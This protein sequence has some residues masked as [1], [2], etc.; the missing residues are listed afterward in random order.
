MAKTRANILI[1]GIVQGVGFRYSAYHQGTRLGL[2]GW[3]RNLHTGQ[4]EAEVE[5]DEKVVADFIAW[6]QRGPTS[7]RVEN[8]EVTWKS[9]AGDLDG[10][11]IAH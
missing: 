11:E 9:H 10:F 1:T 3:V 5:G 6:C 2:N 4:V 7:S 8:V